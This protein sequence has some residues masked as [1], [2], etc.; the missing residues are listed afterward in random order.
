VCPASGIAAPVANPR[1]IV[2]ARDT[3]ALLLR[4]DYT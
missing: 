2:H 4:S 3:A 1:L